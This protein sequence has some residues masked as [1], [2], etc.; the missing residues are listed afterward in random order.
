MVLFSSP[1]ML[2]SGMSLEIFKKWCGEESNLLI[3]PGFCVS[4]TVGAKILSGQ[5]RVRPPLRPLLT[6]SQIEMEDGGVVTVKMQVKNM[7]FSAHAD[8]RGIMQM[9]RTCR[10]RNVVLVHGEAGKMYTRLRWCP[11]R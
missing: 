7:S 3:I 11:P 8:A 10:P 4:G 1:G 6:A 5:R 2:H 9:I